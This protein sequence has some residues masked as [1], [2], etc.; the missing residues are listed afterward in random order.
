MALNRSPSTARAK[1][2]CWSWVRL[3]AMERPRPLPS[4]FRE[5]SPRTKRSMSSSAEMFSGSAEML[6]K[7]MVTCSSVA[8]QVRY[9][10]VPGWAYFWM[11]LK[12]FS[13]TRHSRRPSAE[14][15]GV[16][17]AGVRQRVS[18]LAA[19]RSSYSPV[20]WPRKTFTSVGW[21]STLRL[22]VVALE[23][24]TKSSVS[25]FRRADWRSST[26]RYSLAFS[27]GIGSC[28]SRST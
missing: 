12:R 7:M 8:W 17:S 20:V 10:R 15:R 9:T 24:S 25:F 4:V 5:A 2:P 16:P 3:R 26:S 13:N 6:R 1:V 11:L 28:L 23:A 21:R 19:R 27:L 14:M 22:P 18:F